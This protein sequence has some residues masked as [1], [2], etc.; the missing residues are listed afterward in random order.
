MPLVGDIGKSAAIAPSNLGKFYN[1]IFIFFYL[2]FP[3]II[4]FLTTINTTE[5]G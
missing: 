1:Q 4:I 3:Q 2:I 5:S